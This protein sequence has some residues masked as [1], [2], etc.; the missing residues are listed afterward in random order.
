[1]PFPM[2]IT[3]SGF[4]ENSGQETAQQWSHIS[5]ACPL[6]TGGT[7]QWGCGNSPVELL[8]SSTKRLKRKRNTKLGTTFSFLS[9]L[10]VLQRCQQ[11]PHENWKVVIQWLNNVSDERER[12][13]DLIFT[14]SWYI[15]RYI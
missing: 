1:M 13:R 9:V 6:C 8:F 11:Q 4:Q 14:T 15:L 7:M 2:F 12:E 5:F 3:H 10:L